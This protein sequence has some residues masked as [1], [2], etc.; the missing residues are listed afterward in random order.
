[1]ESFRPNGLS[2][3]GKNRVS[4]WT[5][6]QMTRLLL[7][8]FASAGLFIFLCI[9]SFSFQVF[10]RITIETQRPCLG[11]DIDTTSRYPEVNKK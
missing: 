3:N 7:F 10:K 9:I 8:L 4:D 2:V 5:G 1:M 6:M 11:M